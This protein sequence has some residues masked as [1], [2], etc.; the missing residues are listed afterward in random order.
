MISVKNSEQIKLMRRPEGLPV[1][2]VLAGEA[3]KPGVTTKQLDT[4]IRR[5]IESCGA[6]PS[7]LGMP[8][9]PEAPASASTIRSYT[10]F[11]VPE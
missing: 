5:H 11:P 10:E 7:F 9:F 2:L 8:D 6:K 4:I 3:V 1:R